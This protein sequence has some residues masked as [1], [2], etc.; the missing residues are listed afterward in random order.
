[1]TE[2]T[3]YLRRVDYNNTSAHTISKT[4]KG[5]GVHVI[6]Y[7]DYC[8]T[9]KTADEKLVTR[10]AER[11]KQFY[12]EVVS[13]DSITKPAPAISETSFEI[14]AVRNREGKWFRAKGFTG[15]RSW[16]DALADAKLYT[17]IG[18]AQSRVTYFA[19]RYPEFGIPDV[20]KLT[21]KSFEIIDQTERIK[22]LFIKK[23][24]QK[25]TQEKQAIKYAKEQQE[26]VIQHSKNNIQNAKAELERLKKLDS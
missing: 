9:F 20:V 11:W 22:K 6:S 2:K 18:Q 7:N 4:I 15:K 23:E 8:V 26:R 5:L 24:K 16:A 3:Y 14:Y 12:W 19:T 17:K 10:I 21:V 25:I 13:T 1:M